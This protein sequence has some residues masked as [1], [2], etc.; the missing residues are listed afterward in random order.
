MKSLLLLATSFFV[1]FANSQITIVASDFAHGGDTVRMSQTFDNG[2]DYQTTGPAQTWDF[3]MLTPSSQ[4]LKDFRAMTG[5]PIFVAF[6]FGAMADPAYQANYYIES[7]DLPIDQ[8]T[9]ILPVTITD[10]F[11]YTRFP[12]TGLA[13]NSIGY[14]MSVDFG[15]GATSIPFQSDTIEKRYVLPLNYNNT[16]NSRGYTNI[17]FNPFYNAIWRQYRQR[18][19]IVDGYGTITTPYGIFNALRV[20]HE[21]VETDSI[22]M[23]LP[24]IGGTWI[25]LDL[26]LTREYEWW[27]NGEKE[28]ILKFVTQEILGNEAV[29]AIE[30]RDIYRGLDAGINENGM[31]ISVYPNPVTDIIN[32]STN[33]QV[34]VVRIYSFEGKEVKQFN[35]YAQSQLSIDLNSLVPGTYILEAEGNGKTLRT[36]VTRH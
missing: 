6:T 20:K 31:E 21:I 15:S 4:K 13:V 1:C 30:Y 10:I 22:F 33:F 28:P 27:T 11:S 18:N 12:G 23:E 35:G 34:D 17:D 7:N 16:Y 26:P 25:P 8:I 32:I 9:Q 2:Y 19:S 5:A 3:S 24:F 29:T 36:S 14:S